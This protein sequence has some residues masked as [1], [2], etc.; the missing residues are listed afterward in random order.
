MPAGGGGRA[1]GADDTQQAA[2]ETAESA[3]PWRV[4]DSMAFDDVI[5]PRDLRNAL[6][7]GLAL[8]GTRADGPFAPVA[9]LG[10]L[11]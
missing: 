9:R 8:A 5:D 6:L 7:R 1:A 2:L 4:A 3:A 11:P 10:C